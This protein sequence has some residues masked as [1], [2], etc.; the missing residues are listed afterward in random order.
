MIKF[1]AF[2]PNTKSAALEVEIVVDIQPVNDAPTIIA[3]SSYST[4]EDS[5]IILSNIASR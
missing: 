5:E 3:P 4:V 1:T 2:A